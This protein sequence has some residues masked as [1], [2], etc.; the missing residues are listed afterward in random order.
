VRTEA[1]T[2]EFAAGASGVL[3]GGRLTVKAV[4]KVSLE[5]VGGETLGL[6]FRC[7]HPAS[8]SST[9]PRQTRRIA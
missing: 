1:V 7:C 9:S 8:V 5:I 6:V 2:K 3:G 4:T